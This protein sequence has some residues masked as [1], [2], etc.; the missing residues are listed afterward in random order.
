MLLRTV[1]TS[2]AIPSSALSLTLPRF[3][4][5]KFPVFDEADCVALPSLPFVLYRS[6]RV[7]QKIYSGELNRYQQHA[8]GKD[9]AARGILVKT[10]TNCS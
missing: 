3:F 1:D 9:S 8:V 2:N 10:P 6:V 7:L 5:W 4:F